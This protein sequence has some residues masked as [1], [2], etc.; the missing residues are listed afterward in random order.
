MMNE[1]EVRQWIAGYLAELLDLDVTAIDGAKP[2]RE[3][4]L[5]SADAVIIGGALEGRFDVEVDAT[6]F[7]RNECIDDLM[8]DLKSSG[9]LG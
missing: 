6:L 9:L 3:Y 8:A 5:D 2:F 1:S 4:G 7:L